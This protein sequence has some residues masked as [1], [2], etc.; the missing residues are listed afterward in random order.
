MYM[1][2]RRH[3][4]VAAAALLGLVGVAT[5]AS[6]SQVAYGYVQANSSCPTSSST[7]ACYVYLKYP[8]GASSTT[9][10]RPY[11][12]G[13]VSCPGSAADGLPIRSAI[14]GDLLV[15][16]YVAVIWG[17]DVQGQINCH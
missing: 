15:G 9:T 6:A 2:S 7:A 10:T 1:T 11:P 4:V 8:A 5:P 13:G 16:R 12:I 17:S 14:N 3:L